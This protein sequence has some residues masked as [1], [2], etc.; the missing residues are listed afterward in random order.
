MECDLIGGLLDAARSGQSRVLV[1]SGEPGIGKSALLANATGLAEARGIRV[2]WVDGVESEME[3][4]FA[5]LHQL[6]GPMLAVL[7]RLPEP[8]REAMRTAFGLATGRPP[9]PLLINLA[10]LSLLSEVAEEK[11]L[12]CVVD[13]ADWFDHASAQALAF[14][15]RRL[16]ADRICLLFGVRHVTED[17]R[18]LPGLELAGLDPPDSGALLASA[19]S[20]RLDERV[21]DRVVAETHGNPLALLES[22][23][24]LSLGEL[25]GGFGPTPLTLAGQIE[26]SF[27]RR[28]AELMPATRR[29][30][31]VAAAEPTGDA[32][33]VWRA[34]GRLDVSGHDASPAIEAGLVEVDTTVRFR[35]PSVRSATYGAASTPERQEAH[36]A[37]AEVTD[38]AADP[39]RRAWHLA[40]AASGPDAD[41]ANELE[42]SATR[43]MARGG[44]AAAA[45]LRERSA[46]L[47]LDPAVRVQ[48]IVAAAAAH[49]E[50]GAYRTGAEL[51]AAAE[52]GP[53]DERSRAQ[54]DV[55][56]S[57]AA[58]ILGNTGAAADLMY[59]AAM[60]LER[61]DPP[62]ARPV[63]VSTLMMTIN[64]SDLAREVDLE[65]AARA[66]RSAP[67]SLDHRYDLL[68]DGLAINTTD[69]P[70]AAAS[71]LR[72]ALRVIR[73]VPPG[74]EE[75]WWYGHHSA[76][77]TLLWEY[78]TFL[79]LATRQME[80]ARD[81]GALRML[82]SALET[83]AVGNILGGNL[84]RAATLIG[85]AEA[86]HEATG[87]RYVVY[88]AAQLAAWRGRETEALPVID[89]VI[90][91]ARS[92]AQGLAVKIAQ[93]ARAT[94]FNGIGRYDEALGAA[95]AASGTPFTWVTHLTLH[96]FVEAA[97]RSGAPNAAAEAMDRLSDSARAS[98]TN[99]ALGI[100]ARS[101]A[102]LDSGDGAEA[103][104]L[105]AAERLDRSPVRPEAARTHLLFGEWLRRAN[106]RADARPHL[107]FAYDELI[108][109]QMDAFADRAGRE[110]AA[111]GETVRKRTVDTVQQ[112][113]PQE[114]RIA[115]LAADGVSNREIGAQLYLSVRTVEWHLR[116]VF[117]KLDLANR[118]ELSGSLAAAGHL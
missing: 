20:G 45:A 48:R 7:R 74:S 56:R 44:L 30:L 97:V 116:K 61:V 50:A 84:P 105:E 34:A 23:R 65:R 64:A 40:L 103:L 73:D 4:P 42:R 99:W 25:V 118:R 71:T 102:L 26:E 90:D 9:E 35:H 58:H 81:L 24:G 113:T 107:R 87:S 98:G 68:G 18:G 12:V 10:V 2:A 39:D 3:L 22:A 88:G 27:Q 66:L 94:L 6:C 38:P 47:T 92:H 114:V 16:L 100:E 43:A 82:G 11:P 15:A 41:V 36:R 108:A 53:L 80:A 17:L 112:L 115:R 93:S 14:G 52:A 70:S 28:L 32:A 49:V 72:R 63:Y 29:F 85:E 8:Q 109:M 57:T 69:G 31:T 21:R 62:I 78:E 19:L 86:L 33:L 1:V 110:L 59:S 96:E 117:T 13:N 76:A 54:I 77:A 89:T 111:T 37:L 55:I 75:A 91:R 83:L 46:A 104:Y 79:M 51:L 106:R 5:G 101:R 67:P 95:R 60:R